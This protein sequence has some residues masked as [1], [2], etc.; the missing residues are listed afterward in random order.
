MIQQN[1]LDKYLSSIPQLK[2][3]LGSQNR[4]SLPSLEKVVISMGL[5]SCLGDRKKIDEAA[6]QLSQIA[7]QKAVITKAKNSVSGFRLREGVDVGCCVTLRK[8]RMYSFLTRMLFLVLPRV[9]DFRGL[10]T[11]SFDGFGNY[12]F[13]IGE[14]SVF[15]E[16]DAEKVTFSQGMNVCVV[17]TA[18][19]NTEGLFLLTS[20]GFPFS[21]DNI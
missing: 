18:K 8:A 16:I 12:S 11:T 10:R 17:T 2:A 20:L 6:S 4:H 15:P 19:N 21:K 13:G 5:G 3:A 7:G 14:Q 9:R 1:V